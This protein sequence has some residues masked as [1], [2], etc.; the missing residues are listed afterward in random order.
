M[1]KTVRSSSMDSFWT[2]YSLLALVW[3]H[4]IFF[5]LILRKLAEHVITFFWWNV[6]AQKCSVPNKSKS[7]HQGVRSLMTVILK[8]L[9][10]SRVL[11]RPPSNIFLKEKQGNHEIPRVKPS[12]LF[13]KCDLA[14]HLSPKKPSQRFCINS[15]ES[16]HCCW[17]NLKR[18]YHCPTSIKIKLK[19]TT[20]KWQL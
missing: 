6:C 17:N 9:R 1:G 20:A 13:Q 10:R 3:N 4:C 18:H 19:F 7:F 16:G 15:G 2:C 5:H 12:L 14:R 8:S 11:P